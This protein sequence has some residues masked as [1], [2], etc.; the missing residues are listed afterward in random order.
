MDENINQNYYR[1]DSNYLENEEQQSISPSEFF[2]ENREMNSSKP[3]IELL[4]LPVFVVLLAFATT[5]VQLYK[6][7]I[8]IYRK[9][10]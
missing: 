9:V 7:L 10:D 5:L 1:L 4:Y 3:T 6:L 2:D 8:K